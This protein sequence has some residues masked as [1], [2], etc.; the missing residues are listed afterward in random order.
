[1]RTHKSGL[2]VTSWNDQVK[3][4][5]ADGEEF[6]RPAKYDK[7]LDC[8]FTFRGE[9]YYCKEFLT[10]PP[11]IHRMLDISTAHLSPESIQLLDAV[12]EGRNKE[13]SL[14]L[15][16]K[17]GYGYIIPIVDGDET[18]NSDLPDDLQDVIHFAKNLGCTWIMFDG[19][20]TMYEDSLPIWNENINP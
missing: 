12:K 11:L 15:F 20:G 19:D 13:C 2:V 17:G 5:T 1:M 6:T 18:D 16:D 14:V 3:G 10:L 4:R 7:N 8:Y 9:D